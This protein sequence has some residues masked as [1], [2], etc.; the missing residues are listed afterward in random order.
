MSAD[1]AHPNL[2]PRERLSAELARM[3]ARNDEHRRRARLQRD[4]VIASLLRCPELRDNDA[5]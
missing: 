3:S 1:Y 2:Q 5:R 4:L